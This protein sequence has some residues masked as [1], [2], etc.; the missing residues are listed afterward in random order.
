METT[1]ALLVAAI[2]LVGGA[3]ITVLTVLAIG[4]HAD[5]KSRRLSNSPH[6]YAEGIT[7]KILGMTVSTSNPSHSGSEE[8]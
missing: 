7:R 6:T 3:S 4:I 8:D 5:G 2:L 1:I